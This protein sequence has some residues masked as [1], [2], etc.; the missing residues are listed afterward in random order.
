MYNDVGG[1]RET[2]ITFG[3]ALYISPHFP[4]FNLELET[5]YKD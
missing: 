5:L 1:G 3:M 2:I 4:S